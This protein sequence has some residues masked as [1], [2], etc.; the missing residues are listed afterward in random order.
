MKKYFFSVAIL[1]TLLFAACGEEPNGDWVEINGVKWAKCNVDAFGTFA[2]TP[3]SF[4]VFYQW[5]NPTAWTDTGNVTGWGDIYTGGYNWTAANDPCPKGWRVPTI[6]ELSYLN[7]AGSEWTIVNGVNGYLFGSGE[8]TIFLPAAGYINSYS[9]FLRDVGYYGNYWSSTPDG[10]NAHLLNFQGV[11]VSPFCT[12]GF[13]T[14][15]FSI[16]CV[17]E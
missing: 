3:E 14:G 2:L 11:D 15:G 6:Q 10:T 12:I 8:N 16:R 9:G 1:A 17:K 5:N 7:E 4:G 13:R